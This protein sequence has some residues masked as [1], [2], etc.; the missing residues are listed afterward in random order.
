[1]LRLPACALLA[2][3]LCGFTLL[4][5]EYRGKVKSVDPDKNTITVMVAKKAMTFK[6]SDDTRFVRGKEGKEIRRKLKAKLWEKMPRVTV[7]TEG[8]G[9]KEVAKE[10]RVRAKGGKGAK[11]GKKG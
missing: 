4:A 1:M 2:F 9:E 7:T 3:A 5:G 10:V 8:E 11:A 6:V